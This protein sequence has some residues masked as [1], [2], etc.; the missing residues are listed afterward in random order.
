MKNQVFRN[1]MGRFT[2]G[3]TVITTRVGDQP[4]GMTANAFMSVSMDPQLICVSIDNH[5]NILEKI[6]TT[7]LFAVN[8]LS[9]EQLDISMHFAD[10]VTKDQ[11]IHFYTMNDFPVIKDSLASIICVLDRTIQV[12]DHTLFI[13][14]VTDIHLTDGSPLT[15][16]GGKY[17]LKCNFHV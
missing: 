7:E 16:F 17:V 5:A 6:E 8:I 10:Q 9:E 3:V 4:Y 15:F 13:G 12:G 2:T 1:A 11:D 14:K